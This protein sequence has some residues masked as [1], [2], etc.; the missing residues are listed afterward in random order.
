ML[1]LFG[2]PRFQG[3]PITLERS[4]FLVALLVCQQKPVSRD[5]LMLLLWQDDGERNSI[6]QRLRQLAYRAKQM[7]YGAG[8]RTDTQYFSYSAKSDVGEFRSAI[9]AADFPRALALY[10]GDLLQGAVFEHNEL[11]EWFRLERDTLRAQYVEAA[12][13]QAEK[14]EKSEAARLLEGA[15]L[16]DPQNEDLLRTV[17]EYA[18]TAPEVGKRAFE[19]FRKALAQD[20]GLEPPQDLI[21]LVSELGKHSIARPRPGKKRLPSPNTAFIGRQAEIEELNLLL[22]DCRLLTL[23]GIGGIG[24]TRLSLEIANQSA[25]EAIFIDLARLN[26]AEQVPNAILEALGETAH[27]NPLEQLHRVLFERSVLL[28]FDNFEH[29]LSARDVV[30]EL[31]KQHPQLKIIATSRERLGLQQEQVYELRGMPAP[32]TIFPLESQDAAQIFLRAAQRTQLDFSLQNDIGNFSRIYQ[33]VSGIPLGLELSASWVRT[34]SLGEIA[35]ELEQS[36]DLIAVDSPDMPTRHRSFAAVFSSS[37]QLLSPPEQQTLAALSVFR[38]GFDKELATS[39]CQ[40]PLVLLLKLVNKSLIT[41]H[42]ERF[43][44]HELVRQY[45]A[46]Q[47]GERNPTLERLSKA[48][49]ELSVQWKKNSKGQ[50]QTELSRRLELEHDNIRT[51]LEWSADNIPELGA[52]IAGNLEHFWYS[53]GYHKEGAAWAERFL[54]LYPTRD[55]TRLDLLWTKASLTKELSDYN[56][57]R[58]IALEYQALAQELDHKFALAGAQKF[59][60]LLERELGHLESSKAHLERAREMYIALGDNNSLG[61]CFNDLGIVAALQNDIDKAKELFENSLS[62]KRE[63]GDKQGIAYAIGNLGVIAGMQKDYAL[64]RVLQTESLHLKHELGDKQGIANGLQS[65]GTNAFVQKQ[66]QVAHTYFCEAL[67]LFSELGRRYAQTILLFDFAKLAWEVGASYTA[68]ELVA[69]AIHWRYAIQ[70]NPPQDWLEAQQK[71][72]QQSLYTPA[73]LAKLEFDIQKLSLE[74]VISKALAWD[75]D[76]AKKP[77]SSYAG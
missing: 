30:S 22:Q 29:I 34:L 70:S 12:L 18:Q 55:Q 69:S 65:L 28:L 72:Q 46:Q 77:S 59:F 41:R 40:A 17:L 4:L 23:V 16:H 43:M 54:R 13:A 64:E 76:S 44:L 75:I 60:G 67:S 45:S 71:W 19:R 61:I 11:E 25:L 21:Q 66:Y 6:K 47:L 15:L 10:Q 42:G 9:Q 57:A 33:A 53:R 49:L 63:A 74:Q 50:Q 73:E 39:V 7:P 35:D 27:A 56:S 52:K 3:K 31:L 5:E 8:I 20:L 1:T 48:M 62:L 37:W 32:D 14:L 36:L 24:K 26:L 68:L 51:A 38:G 2:I 58:A